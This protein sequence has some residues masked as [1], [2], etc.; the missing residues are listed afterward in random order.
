MRFTL[1]VLALSLLS[2]LPAFSPAEGK[3][4]SGEEIERLVKQLGDEDFARRE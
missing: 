4:A 2:G 3:Q 1:F